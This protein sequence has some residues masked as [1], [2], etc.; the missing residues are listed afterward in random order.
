[1]EVPFMEEEQRRLRK[2]RLKNENVKGP[3]SLGRKSN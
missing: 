2:S 3:Y 1:M